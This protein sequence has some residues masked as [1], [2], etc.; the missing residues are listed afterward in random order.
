MVRLGRKSGDLA[1]MLRFHAVAL[2][3][4]GKSSP[5]VTAARR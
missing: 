2:L 1:T 5:K 4:A 3:G